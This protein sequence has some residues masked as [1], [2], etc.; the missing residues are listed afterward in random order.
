MSNDPSTLRHSNRGEELALGKSYLVN[1]LR[2]NIS[3]T[4]AIAPSSSEL[5]SGILAAA[6]GL[7]TL[8]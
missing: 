7:A 8:P 1:P 3:P 4:L 5:G 6:I 2:R